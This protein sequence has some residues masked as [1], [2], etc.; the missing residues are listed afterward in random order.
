MEDGCR[1]SHIALVAVGNKL[2]YIL[3]TENMKAGDIIKTSR[4]LPRIPGIFMTI[5]KCFIY[6]INFSSY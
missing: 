3:A 2:K 5:F 1:T 6:M 4:E